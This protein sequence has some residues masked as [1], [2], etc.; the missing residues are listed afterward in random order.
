MYFLYCR[1][2]RE[3]E[4]CQTREFFSKLVTPIV[5]LDIQGVN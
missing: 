1:R 2:D 4:A 5:A 3:I